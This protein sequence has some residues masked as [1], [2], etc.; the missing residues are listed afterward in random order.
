ME[1]RRVIQEKLDVRIW[2]SIT[3][4]IIKSNL[5][6]HE[7]KYISH[8]APAISSFCPGSNVNCE[9]STASSAL[10]TCNQGAISKTMKKKY[11]CYCKYHS[12]STS[13]PFADNCGA[14]SSHY[15]PLKKYRIFSP[16]CHIIFLQTYKIHQAVIQ[17]MLKLSIQIFGLIHKPD[18]FFSSVK[19]DKNSVQLPYAG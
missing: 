9:K 17:Y 16:P 14:V 3:Y 2:L 15:G 7:K 5:M 19:A 12:Y 18:V 10:N 4:Q 6:Q 13:G 11:I 8:L 1:R